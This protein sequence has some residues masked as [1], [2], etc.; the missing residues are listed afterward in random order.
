MPALNFKARFADAVERGTK[1]QT[2]RAKRKHP[3]KV[4]DR[5]YHYTGMRTKACRKLAEQDCTHVRGIEIKHP[6][7]VIVD[8]IRLS[9]SGATALARRDGFETVEDFIE[10]FR[11]EHGL[12]FRGDL[13][14]W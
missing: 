3:I 11:A 5:L 13:I 14:E 6:D 12:P 2:I 7:G 4:G 9:R 8:G 1:R 10:F